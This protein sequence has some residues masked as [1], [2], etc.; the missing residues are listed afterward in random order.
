MHQ[1]PKPR[2]F[3]I[4]WV[5]LAILIVMLVL[6]PVLV[7]L[8]DLYD[9][10]ETPGFSGLTPES[11][12]TGASVSQSTDLSVWVDTG[13]SMYGLLHSSRSTCVPSSYKM[14]LESMPDIA[15]QYSQVS[16]IIYYHFDST[17]SV[18]SDT[19]TERSAAR[20]KQQSSALQ[21][22]N[23]NTYQ[24][25]PESGGAST[26]LL[27][28]FGA[29][30]LTHP[31][32]I[33]TDFEAD[34]L[35]QQPAKYAQSLDRIFGA[36]YCVSVVAMKSAF[37]GTLYNYTNE[38]VDYIYGTSKC[39]KSAVQ[40]ISNYANH[41]QPR[42][43]Y[44]IIIGTSLQCER[45]SAEVQSVYREECQ[46]NIA[47]RIEEISKADQHEEHADNFIA[48]Q[49]ADFWLNDAFDIVTAVNSVS[50]T[51]TGGAKAELVSGSPWAESGIPE[52][53]LVTGSQDEAQSAAITFSIVPASACYK[54]TYSTDVYA[55]PVPKIQKVEESQLESSS[56][57]ESSTVLLARGDKRVK[58]SLSDFEDQ[59]QWFKCSAV[60]AAASGIT[61]RLTVDLSNCSPGMYRL[62][63][64]V[65]CRHSTEAEDQNGA[66]WSRNW[67]VST[68]RL[69]EEMARDENTARKTVD[70]Y[71]QLEAIRRSEV[72]QCSCE[73]N[74]VAQLTVDLNIQ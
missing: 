38:G 68:G 8:S 57:T 37:S 62:V 60:S 5:P 33:L 10:H 67:S 14:V 64:P 18:A 41:H 58:L 65:Y 51:A 49:S 11:V 6:G 39:P 27:S 70:L 9:T 16:S 42:S 66:D 7:A 30:D 24:A 73:D 71:E 35:T 26:A 21:L 22:L 28:V 48:L 72:S 47:G 3:S 36:G 50:A 63:L 56:L 17:F 43:F 61:F 25:L 53:T 54:T 13:P 69:K 4:F 15:K 1:M 59:H 40:M 31:T 29:I 19:D 52:F 23:E 2:K 20:A 34:G 12:Q 46:A 74:L 55:T 32:I 45:L 44:A